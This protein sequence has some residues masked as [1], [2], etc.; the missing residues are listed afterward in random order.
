M[1]EPA[2]IAAIVTEYWIRSMEQITHIGDGDDDRARAGHRLGQRHE[3][4]L[5]DRRVRSSTRV[6]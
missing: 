1:A 6:P 5:A 2:P 4:R 3:E